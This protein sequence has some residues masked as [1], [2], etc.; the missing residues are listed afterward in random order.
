MMHLFLLQGLQQKP[1]VQYGRPVP[2][3]ALRG[4]RALYRV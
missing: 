3:C 2:V 1:E 4:G